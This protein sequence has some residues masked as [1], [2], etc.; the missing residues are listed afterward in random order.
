MTPILAGGLVALALSAPFTSPALP[1]VL[2]TVPL[3]VPDGFKGKVQLRGF[4]LDAVEAVSSPV[5]GL[6]GKVVV[7]SGKKQGPPQNVPPRVGGDTAVVLELELPKLAP[8]DPAGPRFVWLKLDHMKTTAGKL[9]PGRARL[10]VDPPDALAEKEP[11]N[12]L[13]GANPLPA[14][15]PM[16]GVIGSGGDV[17]AYRVEAPPGKPLTVTVASGGSPADL[18]LTAFDSAGH[19]L[20]TADART[21]KRLPIGT[22]ELV[23]RS[24][25]PGGVVVVVSEALD[26]GGAEFGYRLIAR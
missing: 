14:N 17:D 16:A 7:G 11:N 25:P 22:R 13:A 18:I 6:A 9:P 26:R 12:A 20:G 24:P 4:N 10:R 8:G 19:L 1:R 15:T 3:G 5:A 21:A 23:L 2:Y